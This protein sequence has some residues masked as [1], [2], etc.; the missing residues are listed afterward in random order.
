MEFRK[1]TLLSLVP[2]LCGEPDNKEKE[3][4]KLLNVMIHHSPL[5]H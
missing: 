5:L 1:R 4:E 2:L 3:R